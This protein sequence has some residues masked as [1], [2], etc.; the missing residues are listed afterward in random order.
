[1]PIPYVVTERVHL[2]GG[3]QVRRSPDGC[4]RAARTPHAAGRVGERDALRLSL[5][6][7]AAR[8]DETS[9][10]ASAAERELM[11]FAAKE[12]VSPLERLETRLH[13]WVGFAIMPLFAQLANAGVHVEL[14]QMTSSGCNRG[15]ASACS[16]GSPSA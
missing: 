1:M 2:A 4:G 12:S 9:V 14:T 10:E 8:L 15:G 11:A 3:V 13:P 7:L 6:D 16:W 5:S